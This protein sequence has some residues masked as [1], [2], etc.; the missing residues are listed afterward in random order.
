[1]SATTQSI[2]TV[3]R[4]GATIRFSGAVN[5][6]TAA[7]LYSKL[8]LE[9]AALARSGQKEQSVTLDC[10][11]IESCDS[12]AVALLLAARRMAAGQNWTLNIEGMTGQVA[13]LA[14][15]YGVDE[16]LALS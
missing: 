7:D 8:E 1:M 14:R 9:F 11:P 10:G 3:S 5:S 13:S 15:L 12:A 16:L 6:N 4:E 2:T